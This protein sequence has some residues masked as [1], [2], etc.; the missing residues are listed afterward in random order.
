MGATVCGFD[1]RATVKEQVQSLV[2]EFLEVTVA[3]ES[4]EGE[5]LLIYDRIDSQV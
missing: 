4:G 3:D 2:P 1:V 5:N